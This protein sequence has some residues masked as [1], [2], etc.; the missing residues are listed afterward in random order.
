MC[1]THKSLYCVG[2][3][4]LNLSKGQNSLVVLEKMIFCRRLSSDKGTTLYAL[5][6]G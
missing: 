4:S 1:K 3:L 2:W 6:G 5:I